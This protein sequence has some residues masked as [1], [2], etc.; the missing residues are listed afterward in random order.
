MGNTIGAYTRYISLIACGN[1]ICYMLYEHWT[2]GPEDQESKG[3]DKNL[4]GCVSHYRLTSLIFRVLSYQFY[5]A[6][7]NVR[8]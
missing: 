2:E 1:Y 8:V 3:Q 7:L 4:E 6:K 5:K